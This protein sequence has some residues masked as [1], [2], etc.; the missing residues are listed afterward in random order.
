MHRVSWHD[1]CIIPCRWV[2]DCTAISASHS[3][4][5]YVC[6]DRVT[7]TIMWWEFLSRRR[8]DGFL[9]RPSTVMLIAALSSLCETYIHSWSM[10]RWCRI[11]ITVVV[12][13]IIVIIVLSIIVLCTPVSYTHLDVYKR[14]HT[15]CYCK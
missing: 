6:F 1:V 8:P 4:C 5:S 3:L 10:L 13:I 11:I 2:A 14:Q 15:Q 12:I 9:F 7:C